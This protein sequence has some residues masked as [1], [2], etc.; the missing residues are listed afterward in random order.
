GLTVHYLTGAHYLTAIGLTNALVTKADAEDRQLAGK[1]QDRLDGYPC[2]TWRTGTGRY[3]NTLRLECLDLGD[4]QLVVA[5]H[6]D[7]CTQLTQ[8]LHHVVGKRIIVIDHQ[9]HVA[10][11]L[12]ELPWSLGPS[13]RD[14][15]GCTN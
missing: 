7:I 10:S 13:L 11:P 12:A 14:T 15:Y 9:Q 6:M 5:D 8:V 2:L 1:V 3:N 4:A